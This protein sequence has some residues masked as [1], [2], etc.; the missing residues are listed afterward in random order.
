MILGEIMFKDYKNIFLISLFFLIILSVGA[1]SANDDFDS[2]ALSDTSIDDNLN[3]ELSDKDIGINDNYENKWEDE[4]LDNTNLKDGDGEVLSAGPKTFTD[5]NKAING[6]NNSEITLDSDY[7][8]NPSCDSSFKDGIKITRKLTIYGNG[9]T[10]SGNNSARIFYVNDFYSDVIIKDIVLINGYGKYSGGAMS[11]GTAVNCTFMNNKVNASSTSANIGGAMGGGFAFNC[12][13]MNNSAEYGSA[14]VD[15]SAVNCT[16]INHTGNV[17]FCSTALYCTFINNSGESV[18]AYGGSAQNCTFINNSV[19]ISGITAFN[20]TFIN[21]W[22]ASSESNVI[23]CVFINNSRSAMTGGAAVNCS[24]ISNVVDSGGAVYNALVSNCVFENN[25][26]RYGGAMS[27]GRAINC[28]FIG[29]VA[30]YGGA[31]YNAS[32][33]NDC[34]FI[35]N[36]ANI[37]GND[38]YNVT[39]FEKAK[40]FTELLALIDSGSEINLD[41]NYIFDASDYLLKDGIN[42]THPITIN[43]NGFTLDASNFA[44]MFYVNADNVLFK[45]IV[46]KNCYVRS[47]SSYGGVH[48]ENGVVISGNSTAKNCTFIGNNIY[49]TGFVICCVVAEDCMFVNNSAHDGGIMG[50]SSAINCTFINNTA[51]HGEGCVLRDAAAINCTFINN[52]GS[53]AMNGGFAIN[54]TFINNSANKTYHSYGGAVYN[55]LVS[56][57]VFENNSARYGGAM[58]G[59]R[60]INCSFIGNVADYGGAVYN[61]SVSN[62]CIFIDN[63]ANIEGNDVYNVTYFEKAKTF[64]ELLALIDSGSEINLDSNYIF[65]ASDYLL[66]HGINITRPITINGNGFTL[67]GS[68]LVRFF[69]VNADNVIFNNI[70][71]VNS[72]ILYN[73]DNVDARSVINGECTIINSIF[74]DND[75]S[76]SANSNILNR[77]NAIN[78]TFENNILG[79]ACG[80]ILNGSAINCTFKNNVLESYSACLINSSAR[81][82]IF[83]NNIANNYSSAVDGGSAV[84]C[85]FTDNFGCRG[86]SGGSA[87]NCTFINNYVQYGGA[88]KDS[89]AVNCTFINN[90][91]L[92]GG[93][94]SGGSAVNCTFINNS[95]FNEGGYYEAYGGAMSG[96]SAIGCTFINNSAFNEGGA[97]F[98]SSAIGCTFINNSAQN[99]GA[100]SIGTALN[101]TFINN[102]ALNGGAMSYNGDDGISYIVEN[103][104]FV[105]NTADYVGGAIDSAIGGASNCNFINNSAGS[106]GGAIYGAK[107][108]KCTFKGNSAGEDGTDYYQTTIVKISTKITSSAI[109]A[110]YNVNKYLIV[111]LRDVDG[112]PISGVKVST[113]LPGLKALT[114]DKNGQ[115]KFNVAKLVPKVYTAKISFAGN[116]E[117]LAVSKSVKVTVKKAKVKLTAK[118]KTFKLKTKTKKYTITLKNN[119]NAVLKKYKLTLRVNGKTFKATT[120]SKGQATF[121]ITNL[122]KKGTFKAVIKYAGNKYYNKLSKT[123]KITVKK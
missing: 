41:S 101:C 40:T 106:F 20:C 16:F 43:G 45:N 19:G 121:K 28:S 91:A 11:G 120:N 73:I 55:A 27:G 57:C 69:N 7:T 86:M 116:A 32:V 111:T 112:K 110:V 102:S 12:T 88:M 51:T 105:G 2:N 3:I 37:E 8:Y 93:A 78:C 114:T 77:A 13:F 56:N 14:I 71:F 44:R 17:V 1:V 72:H 84:N 98:A 74:R 26:A 87:V 70:T 118:N 34:I 38:V 21:N 18:M 59:G 100:I 94:M 24:F 63:L 61:A 46:F 35:D 47:A 107:I 22:I 48:S 115:V 95:A 6:N 10:L 122:K 76:H 53:S 89:S 65:D 123:V 67:D 103:S 82:C 80:A 92:N 119:K 75:I 104:T 15:V 117:Y 79:W 54:C 99:G 90:S 97:M 109:S 96:G 108:Y 4:S 23:N 5:L 85:T 62:D 31:V 68:N 81:G 52:S 9:F 25:S 42:I 49:F 29:N 58:S 30:D 60:A 33:S 39:Y 36:L 83:L 50:G 64:T 113:N 66:I